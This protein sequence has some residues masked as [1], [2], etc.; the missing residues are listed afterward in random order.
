MGGGYDVKAP[1]D[2][3]GDQPDEPSMEASIQPDYEDDGLL[4][5]KGTTFRLQE[6]LPAV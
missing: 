3:I 4:D 1:S 2:F 5:R 6:S